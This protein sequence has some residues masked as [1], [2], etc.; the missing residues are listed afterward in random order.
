MHIYMYC[1]YIHIYK[2]MNIYRYINIYT[3]T[4]IYMH[5]HHAEHPR[6]SPCTH[7]YIRTTHIR[8]CN[9]HM[10]IIHVYMIHTIYVYIYIYI[11]IYMYPSDLM[12][13]VKIFKGQPYRLARWKLVPNWYKLFAPNHFGQ[14][15]MNDNHV[16]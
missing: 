3:Y 13:H 11:Y 12:N 7:V 16:G 4:Y 8:T 1:I 2:Y 5:T 14:A 15:D 6:D 10:Y 9:L